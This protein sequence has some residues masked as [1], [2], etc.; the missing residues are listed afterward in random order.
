V[1]GD[2]A[3]LV[4]F[5]VTNDQHALGEVH[6]TAIEG[7]GFTDAQPTRREQSDDRLGG[8]SPAGRGDVARRRHQVPHL[9]VRVEIGRRALLAAREQSDRRHAGSWIE[10]VQIARKAADHA[11]ATRTPR[12]ATVRRQRRP[13]EREVHGHKVGAALFQE[14]D[15]LRQQ[16]AGFL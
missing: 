6:V 4:E 15:E 11:Q 13:G 3:T 1:Q 16:V 2:E 7:E 8:E 12:R 5:R 9:V 10:R 14:R